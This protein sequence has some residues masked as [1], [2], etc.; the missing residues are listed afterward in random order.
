MKCKYLD[1]MLLE[2]LQSVP[3]M[4]L[5]F[6]FNFSFAKISILVPR[7]NKLYLSALWLLL[8]WYFSIRAAAATLLITH[9]CVSS[10]LWVKVYENNR[11][12]EA[13]QAMYDAR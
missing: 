11:M 1:F 2:K 6:T 9:R 4:N 13:Y 8:A 7:I 5:L 12:L 10:C 3:C